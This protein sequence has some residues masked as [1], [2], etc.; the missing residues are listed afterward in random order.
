MVWPQLRGA[1]WDWWTEGRSPILPAQGATSISTTRS[2]AQFPSIQDQ[3]SARDCPA[4]RPDPLHCARRRTLLEDQGYQRRRRHRQRR[5]AEDPLLHH[6]VRVFDIL[7]TLH[8]A[9]PTA[10]SSKGG[11]KINSSGR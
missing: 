11:A 3:T 8:T 4:P 6:Y 10:A 5:H 9:R 7:K 1:A 2:R